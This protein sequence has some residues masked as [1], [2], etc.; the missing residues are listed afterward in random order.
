MKR[1]PIFSIL[2]CILL[3]TTACT[4][5]LP[6]GES[7]YIALLPFSSEELGARGVL[8]QACN[9]GEPGVFDCS[10]L[11]AGQS[12]VF[13]ILRS[14]PITREEFM[15]LLVT[16]LNLA[17]VPSVRGTYSGPALTWELYQLEIPFLDLGPERFRLDL[18]LAEHDAAE[19]GSVLY[20]IALL[21]LPADYDSHRALYDTL[22]RH[23]LHELAPLEQ[24]N[25]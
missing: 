5:S 16:D 24:G 14:Y 12:P 2:V 4:A 11:R 6:G 1:N 9:Q 25:A 21:T 8:P 7:G 19:Q 18:A 3:S 10:S 23:M 15:P 17:A 20:A 13:L 22:L